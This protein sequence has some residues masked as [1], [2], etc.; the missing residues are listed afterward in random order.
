M[1][2]FLRHIPTCCLTLFFSAGIVF[3]GVIGEDDRRAPG[4]EEAALL[5]ALGQV[6]CTKFVD[7]ERRVTASTGTIV[8]DRQ[9]VLE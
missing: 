4:S 9:A 8:G 7:G 3:A 1:I 5:H 6:F 2:M